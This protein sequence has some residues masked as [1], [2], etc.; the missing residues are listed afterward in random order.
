[1]NI[2][3]VGY[4]GCGKTTVG[5]RLADRLWQKF[6]DVDDVIVK[7]AGKTIKEIFEQVGEPRF[8]ELET[9]SLAEILKLDDHVLGLGG[10][11]LG[12]DENR[13]MLKD[14]GAKVIYL[15]CD[16][17]ELDRRCKADANSAITRPPLTELG[18]GLE[19]IKMMLEKRE[20]LYREAKTGELDVTNLTPEE[21]LAYIARLL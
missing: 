21:T 20:P 12:R 9:E 4:R 18:G 8:R 14:S 10:G 15:K 2:V 7:K 16:P 17:A 19:E 13:K 1:M 6:I 11:T 3:L 5:K